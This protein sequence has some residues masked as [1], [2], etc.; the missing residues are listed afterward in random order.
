MTCKIK[1]D[2]VRNQDKTARFRH[3]VLIDIFCFHIWSKFH[4]TNEKLVSGKEL[5]SKKGIK[6]IFTTQ[7]YPIVTR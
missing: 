1:L 7:D 2:H 5:K 4:I 6:M 3:S